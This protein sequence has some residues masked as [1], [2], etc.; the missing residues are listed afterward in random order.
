ME[1]CGVTPLECKVPKV[2][3]CPRSS[4]GV[5]TSRTP[6]LEGCDEASKFMQFLNFFRAF[7]DTKQVPG[8]Y[9][10]GIKERKNYVKHRQTRF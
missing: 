4:Q 8:G 6:L 2:S 5:L 3:A 7:H 9:P 1:V 10:L